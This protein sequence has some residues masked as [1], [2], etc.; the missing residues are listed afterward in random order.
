MNYLRVSKHHQPT[1]SNERDEW[2][3]EDDSLKRIIHIIMNVVKPS[4]IRTRTLGRIATSRHSHLSRRIADRI[5]GTRARL[6]LKGMEE[7]KPVP[8]FVGCRAS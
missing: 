1:D 8:D 3:D 6:T 4:H 2:E 7:P 5:P